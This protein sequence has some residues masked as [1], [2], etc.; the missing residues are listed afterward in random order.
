MYTLE[1]ENDA[2]QTSNNAIA[3]RLIEW[4]LDC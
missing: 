3:K 1:E 4:E 2:I